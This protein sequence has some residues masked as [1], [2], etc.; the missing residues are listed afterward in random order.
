VRRS[1]AVALLA[2]AAFAARAA[3]SQATAAAK[4]VVSAAP[5]ESQTIR[6]LRRVSLEALAAKL[7]VEERAWAETLRTSA[8]GD[9]RAD[10]GNMIVDRPDATDFVLALLVREKDPIVLRATMMNIYAIPHFRKEPRIREVLRYVVATSPEPA[11]VEVA[12]EQLRALAMHE[13]REVMSDRM[14]RE[15]A[16]G[17]GELVAALAPAEDR[18]INLDRGLMLPTFLRRSP[19]LFEKK[20]HGEPVRVLAFGDYGTGSDEQKATAAAMR[21]YHASHPFDFGL[22]LGDN[23]YGQGLPSPDHPRWKEQFEELYGPM[24]IEIFACFGNH[25]EYDPD[26]PA[27]EILRSPRSD[28]WRMPTQ[29]YTYTAGPAQFFAIDCNDMSEVQQRWLRDALDAS[30]ARWKIVYGHF[31][32]YLAADYENG[33]FKEFSSVIMPILKGRADVYFAGHHHSLQHVQDVDGVHLFISG[34]GGAGTYEVDEKSP[35]K[36]FAKQE[37][38]FAVMEIAADSLGVRFID[39]DSHEL[40]ET[41]IS[42]QGNP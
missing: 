5:A 31:P 34:G 18:A 37:N 28:S 19:P 9:K 22:T 36:V 40:Y 15:R 41:T 7:P 8:D 21:R 42:K 4:P 16:A 24:G 26:S 29:F 12:L 33:E 3:A 14:A 6:H 13:L 27:A 35:R 17:H 25:D 10:A 2:A 39:K 11:A 20:V 30:R 32:P 23:F 38:G 1:I